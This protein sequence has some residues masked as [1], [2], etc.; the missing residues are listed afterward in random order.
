VGRHR[1]ARMMQRSGL[2]GLTRR[3][4]CR[5]TRRDERARPAP[6][7][8]ERDFTAAGPDRRWV[9]DITYV[10]TWSGFLFLAVVV[11]VFSRRV[12][13]WSMSARQQTELVPRA[14]R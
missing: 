9:A 12:V 1:V 4:F 3:R 11:D 2:A 10:P 5:T 7:L 13:G 14:R 8:L 6:D